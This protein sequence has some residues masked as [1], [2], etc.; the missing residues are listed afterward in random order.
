MSTGAAGIRVVVL[1]PFVTMFYMFY[2]SS[3]VT[4]ASAGTGT[5][6]INLKIGYYNDLYHDDGEVYN[7]GVQS[8]AAFMMAVD[9]I[10]QSPTLL[11][12]VHLNVALR[13]GHDPYGAL[14]AAQEFLTVDFSRVGV[15][16]STYVGNTPI[17]VDFVVGA[18]DND[19]TEFSD[20]VL[21][22][23]NI[24]QLHT[25]ASDTR[26]ALGR[27]YT[28]N[29]Y[30][31]Q[32][33]PV[34]SF[35]GMVWQEIMC[36]YFGMTKIAVFA[37]SDTNSF[38]S[39]IEVA[40]TTYC[41]LSKMTVQSFDIGTTDFT[42]VIDNVKATGALVFA[43]FMPA[44]SA[45]M[46]IEQMYD[47]G[48]MKEGTQVFA[49]FNLLDPAVIGAFQ[50]P[51]N[52]PAS[53][54]K[55]IMKGAMALSYVPNYSLWAGPGGR[56]FVRS[57]RNLVA[58]KTTS[59]SVCSSRKDDTGKS[60][61]QKV[62]ST[63]G[64][65]CLGVDPAEVGVNG[66]GLYPYAAHAYD[67]VYSFASA[68]DLL[69]SSSNG[70]KSQLTGDNIYNMLVNNVTISEESGATGYVR[71]FA[72][73]PEYNGQASGDREEGNVFAVY[74]FQDSAYDA[75]KGANGFVQVGIW[76]LEGGGFVPCT[77]A[78]RGL[79]TVQGAALCATTISYRTANNAMPL[80]TPATIV[81][82]M[83]GGLRASLYAI[84]AVTVSFVLMFVA[85]VIQVR[86]DCSAGVVESFLRVCRTFFSE[87]MPCSP[88]TTVH[89]S[90][91]AYFTPPPGPLPHPLTPP[92]IRY[93]TVSPEQA[94][95]GI[96]APHG[97]NHPRGL[98]VGRP[99]HYHHGLA[100]F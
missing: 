33:L 12:N 34:I 56:R 2:F 38:R 76:S 53:R 17:G 41:G 3:F 22:Q 93:C 81:L 94:Y 35:Q 61:Y 70:D 51:P 60:M 89:T 45:G 87:F 13:T 10:N 55:A 19:E 80:D 18:G 32:N 90:H 8:F 86:P 62:L 25:V 9:E 40:D 84:G 15:S 88:S 26:F 85:I 21:Q 64:S 77:A 58:T 14:E 46:L 100:P 47:Q 83:N 31:V 37:A 1:P 39:S 63:G 36:N 98:F 97:W 82:S 78:N 6:K 99:T 20:M 5:S 52:P 49:N 95:E 48:L 91:C 29:K 79:L 7:D 54:V 65:V 57:F 43:L 23:F 11:P 50:N 74:N 67:A 69:L 24:V 71:Y 16:S 73:M 92:C 96:T 72:G 28:C 59:P 44:A 75:T 4:V 27:S 68:V 42:Y 30:K 66:T